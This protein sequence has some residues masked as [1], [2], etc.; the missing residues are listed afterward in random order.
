MSKNRFKTFSPVFDRI[1]GGGFP[2][3]SLVLFEDLPGYA[4]STIIA[5][6]TLV[7]G[8]E[9]GEIGIYLTFDHSPNLI[10]EHVRADGLD[11]AQHEKSRRFFIVDGFRWG[12][13]SEKYIIKDPSSDSELMSVFG[14]IRED[15]SDSLKDNCRCVVDS[16]VSLF[17]VHGAEKLVSFALLLREISNKLG[18][19]SIL[20]SIGAIG[21]RINNVL[22]YN[23]DV[24]VEFKLAE[25]EGHQVQKMR[26]KRAFNE[27]S[28]SPWVTAIQSGN[29]FVV[30]DE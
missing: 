13:K 16:T 28:P 15:C 29:E 20:M 2:R 3:R 11:V 19:S 22:G 27:I 24:H 6:K 12:E 9:N 23:S 25:E 14:A 1:L 30:K 7:N 21:R 17:F 26:V 5:S 10:R 8:V 4:F 18:I